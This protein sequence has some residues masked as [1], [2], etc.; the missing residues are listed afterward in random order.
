[1]LQYRRRNSNTP[2]QPRTNIARHPL[3]TYC[4]WSHD[5][6]RHI[7][8]RRLRN[9]LTRFQNNYIHFYIRMINETPR[10]VVD[11]F[12]E[13]EQLNPNTLENIYDILNTRGF[14]LREL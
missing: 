9:I 8:T 3:L 10:S 6:S 14:D 5:R 1:M 2:L 4:N 13:Q 12:I 7:N 11:S